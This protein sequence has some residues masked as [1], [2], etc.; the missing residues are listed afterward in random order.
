MA[1]WLRNHC[2]NSFSI[3]ALPF[4]ILSMGPV[5]GELRSRCDRR[6]D[7]SSTDERL[8]K[9]LRLAQRE[10]ERW[11]RGR[12]AETVTDCGGCAGC[13]AG[14]R[15]C[16]GVSSYCQILRGE[17]SQAG[18]AAPADALFNCCIC[19]A[20]CCCSRRCSLSFC[21]SANFTTMG[22]E[23]PCVDRLKERRGS[24]RGRGVKKKKREI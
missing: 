14:G 8:E 23:Q 1:P 16:V 15:G 11:G 7:R 13:A 22:E 21:V 3:A 5:R 2:P 4:R 18:Q 12:W 6:R 9:G 17:A 19:C 10:Q 24:G 20:N